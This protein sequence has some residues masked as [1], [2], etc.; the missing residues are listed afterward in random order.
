M[1]QL[2]ALAQIGLYLFAAA[3]LFQLVTLPVEFNASNRALNNLKKFELLTPNELPAAK[4]VLTAAAMTYVAALAMSVAY[5]LQYAAILG[6]GR[7]D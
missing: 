3:A 5:L 7:D 2:T 1:L 4:K 6:M